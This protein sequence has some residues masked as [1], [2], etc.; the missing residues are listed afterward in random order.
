DGP[1]RLCLLAR[2]G[3]SVQ[4]AAGGGAVDPA[5]ELAVLGGDRVVVAFGH[6]ALQP[7]GERLDGRAEPQ[8]LEPLFG[9]DPDALLLLLDVRHD[10]KTPAARAENDGSK[11]DLRA[12]G[13]APDLGGRQPPPR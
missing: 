11:G 5:D 4:R 13:L 1:S 7:A 2:G 12:C 9:G 8:V 3:V 6:G 10:A